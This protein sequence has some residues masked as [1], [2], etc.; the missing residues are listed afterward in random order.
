M[1]KP[2]PITREES[3]SLDVNLGIYY[4]NNCLYAGVGLMHTSKPEI[5]LDEK[6]KT[7]T[8]RVLNLTG[9]YNI[10]LKNPLY[11]LQPSLLITTDFSTT[12]TDITGRLIYNKMVNGGFSWRVDTAVVV[13]LGVTIGPFQAG[14]SYDILTGPERKSS[15]G[16][17]EVMVRYQLK[18]KSK[19]TKRYGYKSIRIL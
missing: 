2:Y 11:E 8:E 19:E 14:Y 13:L 12:H 4:A 9:G 3:S 16:S 7:T 1:Y 18:W 17:H 15:N 5:D 10:R 6:V